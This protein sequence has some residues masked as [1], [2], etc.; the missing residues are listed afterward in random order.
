MPMALL[1]VAEISRL[2]RESRLVENLS[3]RELTSPEGTGFD[4]RLGEVYKLKGDAFLGVEERNTPDSELVAAHGRETSYTLKP[5]EYILC[6]TLERVNLPKDVSMYA[7]ARST[8]YRSG[9]L[10]LGTQ[11]APGYSG[12]LVFGLKNLGESAVKLE[13]GARVFHVHFHRASGEGSPYRGQWVEGRISTGGVER[14]V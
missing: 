13:M 5:G 6:K 7:M 10:F 2:V 8:L 1:G 11:A 14:Q 4:L 12:P 9:V 3:E